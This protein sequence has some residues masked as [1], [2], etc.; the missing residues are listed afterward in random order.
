MYETLHYIGEV[1][2]QGLLTCLLI[3][4]LTRWYEK[5]TAIRKAKTAIMF[6]SVEIDVH[7]V[8]LSSLIDDH[9]TLSKGSSSG[10]SCAYWEEFRRDLAP[11]MPLEHLKTLTLYYHSVQHISSLTFKRK[12]NKETFYTFRRNR[13]EAE[14]ITHFLKTWECPAPAYELLLQKILRLKSKAVQVFWQ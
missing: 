2:L 12:P 7:I 9:K 1:L 4:L 3:F 10:L 5:C 8:V 6:I 13:D 14:K 11:F